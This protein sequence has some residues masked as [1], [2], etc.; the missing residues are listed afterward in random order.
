[1]QIESALALLN[2]VGEK[3]RK[4]P[5]YEKHFSAPS[6]PFIYNIFLR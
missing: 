1:M 6:F 4:K 5:V 3:E 2:V